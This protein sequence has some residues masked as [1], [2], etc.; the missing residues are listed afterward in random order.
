MSRLTASSPIGAPGRGH[1]HALLLPGRDGDGPGGRDLDVFDGHLAGP[2]DLSD[3]CGHVGRLDP[4]GS[5]VGR[6]SLRVTG[7][8]GGLPWSA[9]RRW[10]RSWGRRRRRLVPLRASPG[11]CPRGSGQRG[12]ARRSPDRRRPGCR[13]VPGHRLA[14]MSRSVATR[15]RVTAPCSSRQMVTASSGLSARP[16]TSRGPTTRSEKI[17]A[18]VAGLGLGVEDLEGEQGREV[19]VGAEP[20]ELRVPPTDD[21]L[22]GVG[23][24][25]SGLVGGESA[26]RPVAGDV[27]VVAV[28]SGAPGRPGT[29]RHRCCPPGGRAPRPRCHAVRQSA[30][31]S[32]AWLFGCRLERLQLAVPHPGERGDTGG[33]DGAFLAHR[34]L[35]R[36]T[37]CPARPVDAP[38]TQRQVQRR[39]AD[40]S[41]RYGEAGVPL[42]RA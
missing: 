31:S 42:R 29:R 5:R 21:R 27:V 28:G 39:A 22:A 14:S 40:A 4:G 8:R 16:R 7:R 9:A 30:R 32:W 11:R 25:P 19:R 3:E 38:W 15:S 6:R 13:G 10:A 1:G 35:V 23:V 2:E 17:A 36:A 26:D 33:H 24:D 41:A 37:S 34:E 12:R 20:A 18:F